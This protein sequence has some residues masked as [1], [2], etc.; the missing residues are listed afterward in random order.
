MGEAAVAV[1]VAAA[2]PVE[3]VSGAAVPVEV[4]ADVAAVGEVDSVA[5]P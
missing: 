2:M 3:A 5:V 1:T 4:A